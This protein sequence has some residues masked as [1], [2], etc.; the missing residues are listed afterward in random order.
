VRPGITSPASVVYRNEEDLLQSSNLMDTYL[1]DIL[2]TK[3][4]LDQL[5]VRNRTV[6]S[7]LDVIFWTAVGILPRLKGFSIP[8]HL[9]YWGPLSQFTVHYLGW[10][11]IDFV[12]SFSAV[13]TAGIIRRLST[14]FDLGLNVAVPIALAIA[15]TFSLINSLAG[16]NRINWSRATLQ[17]AIDLALSTAIVTVLVLVANLV[18]PQG[19]RFPVSVILVSGAL[20]YF[21]FVAVRYRMRLLTAVAYR[22]LRARSQSMTS[23]GERVLIVGAGEV[24]RFAIWLLSNENL[25]QAFTIVGMVDDNPRKVGT[26]IDGYTVIS[27]TSAI[28]EL[29]KKYDIGL[30]LF[31]IADIQPT[32]QE[33]ILAICQNT[34]VRII[35]IPDI[36]DQL[37]A[38]FPKNEVER[39]IHF[40]K[41]LHNATIDRLT[42]AYNRTHFM[43]LAEVEFH[44]SQRYGHPLSMVAVHVDYLRPEKAA[45]NRSIGSN[46]L[47]SAARRC[48]ESIRGIDLLGRFGD[49][50][51]VI[52]LPETNSEAAEQVGRRIR[53]HITTT[54]VT[55]NR[56]P[57]QVL[58]TV[59]VVTSQGEEFQQIEA[60]LQQVLE[61]IL[62]L[63]RSTQAVPVRETNIK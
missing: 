38:Q 52:L 47:Q 58:A 14:P 49:D 30:I 32:E 20:S 19:A 23:L 5:Y 2:P 54:I 15:F 33:R 9:L 10:F 42:G 59:N 40:N 39:E 61:P 43:R 62:P 34:G 28:T 51:L 55:T 16:L 12:V 26:K 8:E 60:V 35:P 37:K 41:V 57:L 29:V 6:V 7:D 44:R 36:L 4:R 46:I 3:L 13:A 25:T 22:W 1:W 17:D 53:Q 18:F 24:S 63:R 56:G 48:L 27:T 11:L 31:A 45:Y 50:L 21:G